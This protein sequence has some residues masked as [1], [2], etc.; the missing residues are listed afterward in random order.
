VTEV[1]RH[2]VALVV[3][4]LVAALLAETA[5]TRAYSKTVYVLDDRNL[6]PEEAPTPFFGIFVGT[7]VQSSRTADDQSWTWPIDVAAYQVLEAPAPGGRQ[8]GLAPHAPPARAGLLDLA[9][10]VNRTLRG[11]GLGAKW[12][13]LEILGDG[14]SEAVL[15]VDQE[16]ASALVR[17]AVKL[18]FSWQ[19]S[20][21]DRL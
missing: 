11:R 14:P 16:S 6:V 20:F 8:T 10:A 4:A 21:T 3:E 13:T 19:G 7:G 15:A 2:P 5:P 18:E 1:E 9:W 12:G 17:R